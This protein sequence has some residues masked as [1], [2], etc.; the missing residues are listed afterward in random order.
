MHQ[1]DYSI[2]TPENVDLHL[3]VAGLGNRMLAQVVDAAV[4]IACTTVIVILALIGVYFV[5]TL[6]LDAKTKSLWYAVLAMF[7][8]F[9]IFILSNC[10]FIF[11][12]GVWQGQTVGKK[13]AEIRV[14]E[15][16]GQPL[17][18]PAAIIRNLLRI[19]DNILFLGIVVLLFDKNERRLGDMAAGSIVIRERKPDISTTQLELAP[20]SAEDSLLD[21][22][23]V[24]PAEYDLVVDFLKRR[25]SLAK[26]YRPQVAQKLADHFHTKLSGD[27]AIAVAPEAYLEQVYHSYKARAED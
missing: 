6:G 26:A 4:I 9:F 18:W 11:L 19:V 10:Y 7:T 17:G 12:E 8:I 27:T 14:I 13:V 20:S 15:A 24:S 5:S 23:R 3:E 25:N 21:I 16:N 2:S 22:G 1:P